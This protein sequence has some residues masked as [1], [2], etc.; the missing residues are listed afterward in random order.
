MGQKKK[1]DFYPS[2]FSLLARS[3]TTGLRKK[4]GGRANAGI[5]TNWG[6]GW[7][8]REINERLSPK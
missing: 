4:I 3:H 8:E 1:C 6:G 7:K 2:H 5:V